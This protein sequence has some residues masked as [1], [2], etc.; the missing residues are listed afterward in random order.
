MSFPRLTLFPRLLP[1]L[2]VSLISAAP[3][4]AQTL[5]LVVRESTDGKPLPPP[6]PTKEGLGSALFDAGYIVLEFPD[7]PA[8]LDPAELRRT[9]RS[10]GAD[11]I[12]SV[13]V[14]Y[15][16]TAISLNLVRRSGRADYS[17]ADATNGAVRAKGKLEASNKDR[18]RGVD[19]RALGQEI[20][21]TLAE[22][23]TEALKS[24]APAS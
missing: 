20:G 22:K 6:L 9:A 7:T 15:A 3:I 5:L 10:G 21:R 4:A 8:A 19:R 1:L 18:E 16:E 11:L 23:V 17:L 13:T 24:A 2:L 14:E 12:V